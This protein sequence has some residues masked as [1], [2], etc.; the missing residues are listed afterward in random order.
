[1]KIADNGSLK[2]IIIYLCKKKI[3]EYTYIIFLNS[4]LKLK[5]TRFVPKFLKT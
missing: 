4:V 1:M 5:V 3:Y 2:T